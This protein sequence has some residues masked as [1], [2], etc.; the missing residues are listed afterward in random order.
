MARSLPSADPS[1]RPEARSES[2]ETQ[3]RI[4]DA[5]ETLFIENG[6]SATSLRAVAGRAGVNLAAAHYHFGSKEGLLRACV[7]RRLEPVH[8]ARMAGLDA[9]LAREPRPSVREILAVFLAPL[10]DE[11]TPTTLPRLMAR[12]YGEPHSLSRPLIEAEFTP[13]AR[14]FLAVMREALP[15][16]APDEL[17]WRFHFVIGAMIHLFAFDRPP[18]FGGTAPAPRP[19]R[20]VEDLLGFAV[21]GLER[22]PTGRRDAREESR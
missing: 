9:L 14:R 11:S 10:A 8:E 18:D 19:D 6:Y 5:A 1:R 15:E 21:A 17:R 20:G 22:P 3:T 16:L 4:L 7:H 12:L 13:T 2:A